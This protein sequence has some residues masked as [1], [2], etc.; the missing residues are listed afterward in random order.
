MQ[1]NTKITTR[2]TMQWFIAACGGMQSD[3]VIAHDT[4]DILLN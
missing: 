2:V 1:I 3:E 4:R